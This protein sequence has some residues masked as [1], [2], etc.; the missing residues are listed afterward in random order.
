MTAEPSQSAIRTKLKNS[1]FVLGTINLSWLDEREAYA[2]F[3][4][5]LGHGIDIINFTDAAYDGRSET[6]FGD[7]ARHAGDIG[8][9]MII[10]E[11]SGTDM[12]VPEMP[13]LHPSYIKP[14]VRRTLDRLRVAAI[15]VLLLPR[16]NFAMPVELS[17]EAMAELAGE[18]LIRAFG[19]STFPAWKMVEMRAKAEQLGYSPPLLDESPYNALD[20]RIENELIPACEASG[21]GVLAWAPLAQGMLSGGYSDPEALLPESRAAKRGGVYRER[22]TPAGVARAR[23][24]V[25]IAQSV[26]L[27]PCQLAAA[28]VR[29]SPA[30]LA[31]V[32]GCRTR[33]HLDDALGSPMR[34]AEE[35][36]ERIDTDVNAPGT[37]VVNFFN[38]APWMKMRV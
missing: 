9:L 34:L 3:E 11:V 22:I 2:L 7:W 21:I 31:P 38:S 12:G 28:W 24:F 18:G 20:R 37:A 23:R 8:D 10:A 30:V 19:T 1:K 13:N 26:G 5:A 16:P 15:D 25:E 35:V 32:V 17:L 36:R 27:L 4:H 14:A 33:Q 29:G 6:L